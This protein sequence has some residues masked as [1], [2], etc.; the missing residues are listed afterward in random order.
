METKKSDDSVNSNQS[1]NKTNNKFTSYGGMKTQRRCDETKLKFQL[2]YNY[3]ITKMLDNK[4]I[5]TF[6]FHD[7]I[8]NKVKLHTKI[9]PFGCFPPENAKFDILPFVINTPIIDNLN[10]EKG[11]QQLDNLDMLRFNDGI[12]FSDNIV[13]YFLLWMKYQSVKIEFLNSQ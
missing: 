2:N 5:N 10:N 13:R 7:E 4:E 6:M 3:N 12:C 11:F 9:I 8:Y 1:W